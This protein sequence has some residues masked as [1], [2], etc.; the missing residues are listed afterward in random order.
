MNIKKLVL[1]TGVIALM[2]SFT[3]SEK[4]TLNVD[5]SKSEVKW[6][7]YHLAKSYEHSGSISL[8][9]G[10]IEMTDGMISGGEFV[11]D[12]NSITNSDIEDSKKNAKLV[13]HLKSD[14]FFNSEKYPESTLEIT[15]VEKDGDNY[16]A[17]GDLTIRGITESISFTITV[18]E[19]SEDSIDATA[20]LKIDRSKFKV[21][22]GWSIENAIIANEFD[23]SVRIVAEG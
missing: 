16:T 23:L 13:G 10:S 20:D 21:L 2:A 5:T 22:Y 18:N 11:I 8:K 9:S 12:M 14:D 17:E 6:T 7:G 15:S 19:S 1:M 4:A 3:F